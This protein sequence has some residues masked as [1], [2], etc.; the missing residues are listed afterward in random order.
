MLVFALVLAAASPAELTEPQK[1]DIGCVALTGLVA[2]DQKRKAPGSDHYPDVRDKGRKWAGIVGDRV[3]A[4][5][6]LPA[7]VV[8]LAINEAVKAEQAAVGKSADPRAYVDGRM[9]QCVPLMEA[10][11]A[12]ASTTPTASDP[13]PDPGF[14]EE[15]A[16]DISDQHR[17]QFCLGLLKSSLAEIRGREGAGSRDAKAMGRL[18]SGLE[19]LSASLPLPKP[20][21]VSPDIDAGQLNAALSAE[22]GKEEVMARCLRLGEAAARKFGSAS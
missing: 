7:E 1:R 17:V 12:A 14:Q 9:A 16:K 5:S 6:G 4:Q 18:V 15:L 11:L 21:S 8:G 2:Y 19:T 13:Q 3:T 10:D 20:G 22:P